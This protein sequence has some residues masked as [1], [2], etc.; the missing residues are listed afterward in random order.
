MSKQKD[1]DELAFELRTSRDARLVILKITAPH[2]MNS[3]DL[4][5]ALEFYLDQLKKAEEARRL[6]GGYVS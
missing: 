4:I 3:Q 1:D 5:W 2:E 6:A